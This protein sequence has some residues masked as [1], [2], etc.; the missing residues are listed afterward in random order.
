MAVFISRYL[1]TCDLTV[2]VLRELSEEGGQLK[3]WHSACRE[4]FPDVRN[5]KT[6]SRRAEWKIIISICSLN[7]RTTNSSR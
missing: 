3:A 4:T 7:A 1:K 5:S 6:G 2:V